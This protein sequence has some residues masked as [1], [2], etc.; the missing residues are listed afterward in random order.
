M[1]ND[2]PKESE[3]K[4]GPDDVASQSDP[5]SV[6]WT[7]LD[8]WLG[9]ASL[10]LW[11]ALFMAFL[12][13]VQ[14][15]SLDLDPGLI[16][17]I[18]ELLLLV[19]VWWLTVRRYRVGWEALG[20]RRFRGQMIGLGCGL[21][22]L[23]FTFNFF[24]NLFLALFNLRMQIDLTPVFAELSSPWWLLV[25]GAVVAPIAEEIFFRGFVFAGLRQ[26]YGW[27]KA[28]LISS[29]VFAVIHLTPTTIVPVFILGYIFAYLYHRSNSVWLAISMHILTN[30][31]ALGAA[32]AMAKL[33]WPG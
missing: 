5:H 31:L 17:S 10:G 7:S 27:Q 25:G 6:P 1:Y 8:V 15:L 22:L 3:Q 28:A 21:M 11:L 18:G 19:P 4:P 30:A 26:H 20:L 13:L 2:E 9:L 24:Y 14:L 23:S 12:F 16:L 29:A 33:D 32:L